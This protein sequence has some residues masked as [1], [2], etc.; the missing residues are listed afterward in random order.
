METWEKKPWVIKEEVEGM[1]EGE[2]IEKLLL[3]YY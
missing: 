2:E 3:Y 1:R